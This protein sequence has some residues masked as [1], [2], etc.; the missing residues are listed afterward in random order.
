M[1][2]IKLIIINQ[3]YRMNTEIMEKSHHSCTSTFNLIK[4]NHDN[5][6]NKII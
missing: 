5:K 1:Y 6:L 4:Y 2:W 3:A